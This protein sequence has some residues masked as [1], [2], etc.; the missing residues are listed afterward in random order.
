M[1]K[2]MTVG[3]CC[4]NI[5]QSIVLILKSLIVVVDKFLKLKIFKKFA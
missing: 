5:I 1:Y 4:L 2:N 3:L